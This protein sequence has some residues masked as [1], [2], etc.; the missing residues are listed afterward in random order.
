MTLI[1]A[2]APEWSPK[3]VI[4]GEFSP[5]EIKALNDQFYNIYTFPNHPATYDASS[6]VNGSHI[7]TFNW[8]FVD[9]D[10]KDGVFPSK[11]AFIESLSNFPL[12]PTKI[13]DSGRG[14]H[15]YWR[16]KDLDIMSYL[17]L[18]CRLAVQLKTDPEVSKICQLMRL[19]GYNNVKD[20][21]NIVP[22]QVLYQ[23]ND[24]YD[25]EQLDKVLSP[26]TQQDETYC[27]AHYNKTNSIKDP[28]VSINDRIPL[29]FAQLLEKNLEVKSIWSGGLK[30][31]SNGDFRLAHIMFANGFTRDEAMSTLVNCAKALERSPVHRIGYAES[32]VDK[33]WILET[34]GDSLTLSSSVSEIL[35]KKGT[36]IKGTRFPCWKYVDNTQRGLRL[37]QV[38]GLVAGSGVGKTSFV[39]NMFLGFVSFNPDYDHFLVPLEEPAEDLAVR[40]KTI[41]GDNTRLHNKVHIISNYA[42][43]GSFRNLSFSEIKDYILKFQKKTGRKAGCVVIDHIGAL[44]KKGR[45]GENQDLMDICHN[46][47]AF[48][49]ETN[50]MLIMQSQASR[51]KAGSGDLSLDKSA[52]YGTVFFEAYCDYLITMHQPLKQ[53]YYMGAPTV[54]A[55]KFCKIRHK[56]Q[57]LDEI[58]ED[59][60]YKLVFD[61]STERL[62]ALNQDEEKTFGY[63]L[64][65]AVNA[66]KQDKKT[67]ILSYTSVRAE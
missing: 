64:S 36:A 61:P 3:K 62:R 8:V 59:V 17:R 38:I 56:N 53:V 14:V 42:E 32:I 57:L 24:K 22:C 26:I 65:E 15:A 4:E 20:Q 1:R 44:K 48:A 30:D 51:E 40:W 29:K 55:F 58:K 19:E 34:E 13:I 21:N 46:M 41:C 6:I 54:T 33:I 2:I 11:D 16:V 12:L 25:C 50:T 49:V 67:S 31:R 9:M 37:G 39:L 60:T 18:Q 43:D 28:N 5:T 35:Q 66:R 23:N 63:F 10:L 27:Q 45:S 47:K 52:A 7:D